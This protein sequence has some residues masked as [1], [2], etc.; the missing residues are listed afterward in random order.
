MV[1]T[2]IIGGETL[3][4][5]PW[6]VLYWKARGMLLLSDLHLGKVTHF[7][8]YGAAV[9]LEALQR[10]FNRLRHLT[11]IYRPERICFLGDLFHSH[12]NRE[13]E[14][15]EAWVKTCAARLDLVVGNHDIID[16]VRFEALGISCRD[17]WEI[18][19]F[20]LTH[21]PAESEDRFNISGHIH[22]AVRLAGAGRQRL[23]LPVFYLRQRQLILPAFGA[24]TG[25]HVVSPEPGERLY[26]LAGETVLPLDALDARLSRR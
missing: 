26:A 5:H 8:K 24:F 17:Q 20:K 1:H 15:F 19:P 21:H 18:G 14:L 25:T 10:N 3:E 9:P 12:M 2:E 4:M 13:W 22:P 7:R 6:G 16:P 11:D 23:R